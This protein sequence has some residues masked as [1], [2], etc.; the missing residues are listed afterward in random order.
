MVLNRTM[1]AGEV[2]GTATGKMRMCGRADLQILEQL[3]VK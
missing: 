1:D 3:R 2:S